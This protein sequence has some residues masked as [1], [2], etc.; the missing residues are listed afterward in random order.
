MPK[1]KKLEDTETPH[2]YRYQMLITES[3]RTGTHLEWVNLTRREYLDMKVY[4]EKC[5][6]RKLRVIRQIPVA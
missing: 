2:G 1:T 6:G 3:E 4:L 5:R